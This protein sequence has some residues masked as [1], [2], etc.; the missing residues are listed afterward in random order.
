MSEEG[1]MEN[2]DARRA[3][4]LEGGDSLDGIVLPSAYWINAEKALAKYPRQAANYLK[5]TL[6]GDPLLDAMPQELADMPRSEVTRFI[7]AGMDQDLDVM[8]HAPKVLRDF[9]VDYPPPDPPWLDYEAF[10]PGVRKFQKDSGLILSGF[11]AGVLV[12]GFGTLISKSFVHTGRVFEHGV[13]RLQQN[14]RHFVDIFFPG[15]LERQGDGW[16]L[17]VRIRLIHAQMRHLLN[18]SEE[19]DREAWGVPL[20][21]AHLGYAAACFSARTI[22]HAESVGVSFTQEEKDSI[23][24]IWRYTAYIMGIPEQI[25]FKSYAEALEMHKVGNTCE[26][27][28]TEES[29]IMANALI[30]SAPLVAGV[31]DRAQRRTMVEREIYPVSRAPIGNDLADR[32]RFPKTRKIAI[33]WQFRMMQRIRRWMAKVRGK[34]M[35]AENF[36]TMLAI[37]AFDDAGISYHMPDHDRDEMSSKW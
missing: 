27:P 15:G 3:P 19:W 20:H 32:L 4:A 22:V 11:A 2:S 31:T 21:G 35:I 14:N 37:S 8:R 30:N 18:A 17:T 16:K 5:H 6:V 36:G 29:I 13:R 24:A 25:T 28:M 26:P 34:S 12:D 33:L 23:C 7:Q 10:K 1:A 9:F